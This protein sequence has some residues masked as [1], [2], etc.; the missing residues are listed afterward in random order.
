MIKKA[1]I[2]NLYSSLNYLGLGKIKFYNSKSEL[3]EVGKTISSLATSCETTNF[4]CES[5]STYSGSKIINVLNTS[6]SFWYTDKKNE[7]D[8]TSITIT[9]KNDIE[10]ITSFSIIP[11]PHSYY[12]TTSS[13]VVDFYD[14]NDNIIHSYTVMPTSK[15]EEMQTI[16]TEELS[17]F[18]NINTLS[19][20]KTTDPTNIKNIKGIY[21]AVIKQVENDGTTIRYLFSIDGRNT[22]FSL[23]NNEMTNIEL[24]NILTH[25]MT[26]EVVEN[27]IYDFGKYVTLDIAVGMTT[28]YMGVTPIIYSIKFVYDQ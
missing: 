4:I 28:K 23:E 1:V 8:N 11:K 27:A 25:G 15:V 2:R 9:F 16:K 13:F 3:I 7:D 21:G 18:Y 6:S 5:T 12:G 26:K 10:S 20:V 19:I 24:S 14:E 22:W 17:Y